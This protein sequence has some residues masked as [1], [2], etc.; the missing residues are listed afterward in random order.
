MLQET[1]R[2]VPLDVVPLSKFMHLF[3]KRY[4]SVLYSELQHLPF[5]RYFYL[6]VLIG[7]S[8]PPLSQNELGQILEIDKGS[9]ARMLNYLSDHKIIQRQQNPLDR[10]QHILQLSKEGKKWLPAI[11]QAIQQLNSQLS[12][13][14]ELSPRAWLSELLK[15]GDLLAKWPQLPLDEEVE[16]LL[17]KSKS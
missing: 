9:V 6:V 16:G 12:E 13:I 5:D 1:Y 15:M 10:R 2:Q 7:R 8:E 4:I 11:E 17:D 3:T 14:L